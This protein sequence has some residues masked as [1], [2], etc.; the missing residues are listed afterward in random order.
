A[1]AS[2]LRAEARTGRL[3]VANAGTGVGWYFEAASDRLVFAGETYRTFHAEGNAYHLRQTQ[4]PDPERMV[5]RHGQRQPPQ[6]QALA[7]RES[8]HF[9]EEKDLMYA[10]W[11]DPANPD[12]RYWFWDYLYGSV[13]PRVELP[14]R[15]PSPAAKGS[16]V[17]RVRLYGFTDVYPGNEHRVSVELN[18]R[19]VGSSV[20]WDGLN[21]AELVVDFDQSL[22]DPSGTNTLAL[23]H[24]LASSHP[25]SGQFLESID[26]EYWRLPVAD[27]GQLWVRGAAGGVQEV[28]GFS[29]RDILV[30]ES[31]LRGGVVRRDVRTY[32]S[33]G[34]WAVAFEAER[35]KD[36]LVAEVAGV[37]PT[38]VDPRPQ[39]DLLSGSNRAG[40]LIIAPREFEGTA[41][42]LA[43]F[44]QSSFGPV[45]VVWLDDIYKSFS[46]GRV[47]PLAVGHFMAHAR[48]AWALPPSTVT[49]LGKGSLDRKNRMGYGD[50]FLPVLMTANPWALAESD[51]RLLGFA[52]GVVP[53]AYGR[54]PIVN[55]AEGKAY[56]AKL[57]AAE[58][59]AG[60]SL[61]QGIVTADNP[62]SAGDFHADAEGIAGQLERLGF[63]AV[64]RAFHPLQSVRPVLTSSSSWEA[65]VVTYSGH[66]SNRQV[67]TSRENFLTG[68]DAALLAN[69]PS[70]LF[71]ALTCAV[72]G[73]AAPGVRSL[74][75]ELVLNSQGG[76]SAA[77]APSGL[78][79]NTDAHTLG[80]TFFEHVFLRG[81]SVG[82]ALAA[83]TAQTRGGISGFT[84]PVYSIIGDP[85][86]GT[87]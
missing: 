17:L 1:P 34:G 74:T 19:P 66:G 77:L 61:R 52:D 73:T 5:E 21:P 65:A 60:G 8:L 51:A 54:I 3:K 69:L 31:P 12:A 87:R 70:S 83:A 16:A 15:A 7:F 56:V 39:A 49:L 14:L 41:Q 32:A 58:A 79:V 35:G 10:L 81:N 22:L 55:D 75:G 64:T 53:F 40:Y 71:V 45:L 82:G 76:A 4:I 43:S 47:D 2:S 13:R 26:L 23:V 59:R 68:E 20:E 28:R 85:A 38:V 62:D 9:E 25:R 46:H 78:A 37:R 11:L 72:G 18:G 6:G 33:E 42:A 29:G 27:N 48:S 50:N 80:A 86:V 30:I 67:G 63:A 44:R 24:A 36:Y 84:A 57:R